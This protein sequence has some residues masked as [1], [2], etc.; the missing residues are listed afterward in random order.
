MTSVEIGTGHNCDFQYFEIY[1][2]QYI[3]ILGI[4]SQYLNIR[5]FSLP[6][7]C[8][9]FFHFG[10]YINIFLSRLPFHILH[11]HISIIF[12]FHF[13]DKHISII[14]QFQFLHK[15]IS[16]I[17]SFQFVHNLFLS[18]YHFSFYINIFLSF[19]HFSFYTNIFP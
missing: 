17:L 3:E 4:Y 18:F 8:L 2:S 19:Y 7:I 11:K 13:L 15:H 16:T 14:L 12:A 6:D 5:F 10:F 1:N 9:S